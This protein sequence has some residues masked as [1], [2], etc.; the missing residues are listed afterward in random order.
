MTTSGI[1]ELFGCAR[2]R[3]RKN[4]SAR[5]ASGW[6]T[7]CVVLLLCAATA[8]VSPAQTFKRLA[9]FDG[10]NGAGPWGDLVQGLD[11]NLYGATQL[12]GAYSA[13]TIFKITRGGALTT[14]YSFCAA[15]N[16]PDGS[17]PNGGLVQSADGTFYGTTSGG[18]A[19]QSG[20]VF[21]MTPSG[22]L[23]TL[24]S[25]CAQSNCTDGSG[26]LA[27]L[28]QATDGNFY[29]TTVY[30]GV[31]GLGKY[32]ACGGI[33]GPPGEPIAPG[34][35]TVF[36]I[37]LGG[38][39][40]TLH[41]FCAQNSCPDGVYPGGLIQATDGELYGITWAGTLSNNGTVFKITPGGQLATLHS[42]DGGDGSQPMG[43]LVQATDGNFYG[44]TLY[45]YGSHIF[46]ITPSGTLTT[47]YVFCATYPCTDGDQ[48]YAGMVQGTDGNFY[49]TLHSGGAT[50]SGTVFQATPSGTMTD[51]RSFCDQPTIC[52]YGEVPWAGLVQATNGTF[53]GTA[54]SGGA[55]LHGTVY[56][57]SVGLGW[58]VKTLPTIG[59]VGSTIQIMGTDFTGATALT[60]NGSP[61]PFTLLSSTQIQTTVPSGAG[62]GSVKVTIPSGTLSSK[63][64]FR[65]R[66][67]FTSF[68][69]ASGPVE[70]V[71]TI[72]GVSLAQTTRVG[73]GGVSASFTVVDDSTVNATVPTGAKSGRDIVIST[74]GG[75]AVS[76][77]TFTVN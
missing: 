38:T 8:S 45:G 35:G 48:P 15:A 44:A 77:T 25:F 7:A 40:T 57:L 16:C 62:T 70:T 14:L 71:V 76:A 36:R 63:P 43:R 29:G 19:Y 24:Y 23:T 67:Q 12:G 32:G 9:S 55:Y 4:G 17:A 60:F 37:T 46:R 50:G 56:S 75:T 22:A 64:A 47:L 34:C 53:Y 59:T 52:V 21:S 20:T 69:P 6:K 65:V 66:P 72:T 51:L 18:G 31:S 26:P 41:T 49:G 13:G 58:F 11:G 10:T 42:F 54:Y 3:M 28:V 30:G 74:P 1:C 2:T 5:M 27:G 73:L 68:S 39:L 61:A 33:G